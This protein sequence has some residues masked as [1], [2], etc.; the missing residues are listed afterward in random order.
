MDATGDA[1]LARAAGVP[2]AA[3]DDEGRNQMTSLRFEMGGI[4][5]P[6]FRDHCL[7]LGERFSPLTDGRFWE[8]AMVPG[9]GFAL[10]PLFRAGVEDGLLEE[11]DIVYFQCF[12]VPGEPGVMTFNC[13]H[14]P[15]LK[16]NTTALGRSR[17]LLSGR[18]RI[19]RLA[20]FLTR[21]MPG[22]ERAFLVR[23]A[24]MLGVRESWR[25]V[26]SRVLGP[27]A[28]RDRL[29]VPDPVA[30]GTWYIDI[31]SADDGLVHG[32][33]YEPGEY[34]EIPYGC[35]TNRQVKN[36]LAVGRCVSSSF[37]MQASIRIQQTLIEM[38]EAAGAACAAARAGGVPL[39]EFDAAGLLGR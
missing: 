34:Y 29:R 8:A 27:E 35:L 24:P 15:E 25:V 36:M 23:V 18:R 21:R 26:G 5:V 17:A 6:A 37:E 11:S 19:R 7:A 1:C 10:E 9:R 38:G 30:R 13:P 2:C 28:Y 32:E 33:R 3:G 31:H 20:A 22:F 4:D 14:N 16:Q 39:A 12:S